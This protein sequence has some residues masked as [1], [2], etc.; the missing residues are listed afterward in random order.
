M[1]ILGVGETRYVTRSNR[2]VQS[3]GTEAARRALADSGLRPADIDGVV[4]LGGY[5]HTEDIIAGL[6]LSEQCANALPPPGGNSGVDSLRVA[7]ALIESGQSTAVVIVLAKNGA[8]EARISER[9][10]A[11]PGQ[12]FRTQLERPQ[13]W[14]SPVEW[15]AMIARRH[16]LEHGTRKEDLAAV[17][18]SA[19]RFAGNN[20]RAM[21]HGK[22][23]TEE[24]Y[25]AA[26]MIADPYQL[27]DCC[28]ETDGAAAVIATADDVASPCAVGVAGL[29]SGR[30]LSPDDL[31]N[32]DDWYQIGLTFAAPAAY[33]QAG[34]G[35]TDIDAAMIYDC[36]TFEVI[37]QLEVAGFCGAGDGGKFVSSGAIGPGGRLPVNTHGGLLAEGHLTGVN[38]VVE[39]VRQLRHEAGANQLPDVRHVAVT[40]WGDWGD[41]SMAILAAGGR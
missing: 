4:P 8:S 7:R 14:S 28:L 25:F 34:L 18:L 31:T 24:Q 13:G 30:P 33:E 27:Y 35:P 1:K 29:A 21:Q 9:L 32:R 22:T 41:G 23:L 11:L 3:M 15:Y 17:S 6:G 16:M 2:S 36:F 19:Y 40:G 12:Q 39:A 26:P 37:H 10:M 20:P 5:L 38:H